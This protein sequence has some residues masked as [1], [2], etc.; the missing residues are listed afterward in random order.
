MNKHDQN[1]SINIL[2]IPLIMASL[3]MIGTAA[4]AIWAYNSRQDYKNNVESKITTAVTVAKTVES[5]EKDKQFAE[6]EKKPLRT[7]NGP[8]AFGSLVLQYPK[9]WSAY[10]DDTGSGAA[11]VDGYF[12]PGYVPSI[13]NPNSSFALR[14]QVLPQSYSSV[15]ASLRGQE[16][17]GQIQIAPYTLPS[18]TN[19]IGI[20]VDGKITPGKDGTMI[21]LPL[22]DKSIEISTQGSEFS[23]DFE[24]NILKNLTFSP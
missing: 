13:T 23:A 14:V 16:T 19:V 9:T 21:V 20:R 15:L 24:E 17:A 11:P 8:Q 22:R 18:V 6:L 7:Y 10:I 3:A 2:L 4:F 12:Y 5:S 1:G